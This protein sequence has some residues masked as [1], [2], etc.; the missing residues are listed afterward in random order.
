MAYE[1]LSHDELIEKY[2]QLDE[3]L[4]E[5]GNEYNSLLDG[6]KREELGETIYEYYAEMGYLAKKIGFHPIKET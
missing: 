6:P 2:K 1:T 4:K 5:I 3:E